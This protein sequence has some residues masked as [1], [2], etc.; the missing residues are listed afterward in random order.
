MINVVGGPGGGAAPIPPVKQGKPCVEGGP[1]PADRQRGDPR[2]RV[3][4]IARWLH[5]GSGIIGPQSTSPTATIVFM[6]G[7]Y[8]A[9]SILRRAHGM[10]H[11]PHGWQAVRGPTAR[12]HRHHAGPPAH[13]R[14]HRQ[15][16]GT[17]PCATAF[18]AA[19]LLI[20]RTRVSFKGWE[21]RTLHPDL[22][23]APAPLAYPDLFP[24]V[25]S[26]A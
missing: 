26:S 23:G 10:N 6:L 9:L 17:G 11:D 25:T 2:G 7:C 18:R 1:D 3:P 20:T 4:L 5:D 13:Q 15:S 19:T 12:V 24:S 21:W 8:L 14:G 16:V 22:E